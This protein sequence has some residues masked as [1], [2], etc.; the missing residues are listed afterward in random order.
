MKTSTLMNTW[1]FG[2]LSAVSVS[3]GL[4]Y[5][6]VLDTTNNKVGISAHDTCIYNFSSLGR[7]IYN[8][9]RCS[10]SGKTFS[11][12]RAENGVLTTGLPTFGQE[13]Y[14]GKTQP[15]KEGSVTLFFEK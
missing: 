15:N 7:K 2:M 5:S 1:L 9:I 12:P 6:T 14:I 4:N 11:S 8:G 13:G 3:F 10:P